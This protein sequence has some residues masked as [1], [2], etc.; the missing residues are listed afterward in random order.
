MSR[1]TA[2]SHGVNLLPLLD[3]LLCTMG[4]LIV[5]LGVVNREA[6]LHPLKRLSGKAAAA[7]EH[8]QELTDAQE[9]LEL[10]IQ[11]LLTAREKTLADLENARV[12]LS[13]IEDHS[14]QMEDQLRSL[15][16]ASTQLESADG[17]KGSAQDALHTEV[18]QLNTRRLELDKALQKARVDAAHQPA[19]D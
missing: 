4:T 14:R 1:S 15:G 19:A 9:E 10:H 12:R 5:V 8:L 6:R 13:G 11:Q 7:A 3:V 2:G 17:Q 18:M 16:T